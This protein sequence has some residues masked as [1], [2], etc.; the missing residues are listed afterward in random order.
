MTNLCI[1]LSRSTGQ[2]YLQIVCA[3]VQQSLYVNNCRLQCE[4]VLNSPSW[5]TVIV[6]ISWVELRRP[7]KLNQY[8]RHSPSSPHLTSPHCLQFVLPAGS[9]R[10]Q[11]K[12]L[13]FTFVLQSK[14]VAVCPSVQLC[15]LHTKWSKINVHHRKH[16]SDALPLPIC[17]HYHH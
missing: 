2:D 5:Q 8:C 7:V 4:I 11:S 6:L 14:K 12:P 15:I 3:R 10:L 13:L 1:I 16:A 9:A 17:R